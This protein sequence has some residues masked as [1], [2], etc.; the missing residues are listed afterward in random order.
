MRSPTELASR[1][2]TQWQ[3]AHW[4]EQ[5]LLSAEGWPIELRIGRPPPQVLLKHPETVRQHIQDWKQVETGKVHWQPVRYRYTAEPIDLPILWELNTPS[6]WI[7]A[8]NSKEIS[9]TFFKLER[10]VRKAAPEF[11]SLLVRQLRWLEKEELELMKACE[12]ALTLEPG[13]AEGSPLRAISLAGIDSKFFER[14]RS[15][16]IKLLD[17]RFDDQ[18]SELGLETFLDALDENDHWLLVADLDGSLLPFS[19]MR[20][21]ASELANQ[22]LLSDNILIIENERCLHQLPELESTIA[23]LGAGLNL[24]WLCA[25]WLTRK[26]V[27]YWGDLDTWG[28]SMLASARENCPELTPLLM[29][30]EVYHLLKKKHAVEEKHPLTT[31]PTLLTSTEQELFKQLL[32]EKKG[33]LEQ[34]FLP[35]EW[36]HNS[37][38]EW[39]HSSQS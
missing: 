2:A 13:C 28:L 14:N 22:E 36:V 15:L 21:R 25:D 30:E 16:I 23:I 27:A 1:L 6:E 34:E 37:V 8:I 31:I 3:Q 7:C 20:V 9:Q 10:V 35:R 33:R 4:R 38:T 12:L 24:G 17:I 11:H 18:P 19:Q 32:K 39:A 29:I 5:R 26:R